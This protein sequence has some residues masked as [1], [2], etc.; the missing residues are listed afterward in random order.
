MAS[1][2]P[3]KIL[4][5]G[6]VPCPTCALLVLTRFQTAAVSAVYQAS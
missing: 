2:A 6:K 5:L 4:S 3:L 1:H